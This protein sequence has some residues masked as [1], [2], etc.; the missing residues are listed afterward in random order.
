M[1]S[2]QLVVRELKR[3]IGSLYFEGSGLSKDKEKLAARVK[4]G[5]ETFEPRLAVR[6]PYVF[7]FLGLRSRE[8]MGESD[9]EDALLDRLQEFLLERRFGPQTFSQPVGDQPDSLPVMSPQRCAGSRVAL[10]PV[11]PVVTSVTNCRNGH[12]AMSIRQFTRLRSPS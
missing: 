12:S 5:P 3:Q 11:A 9:L 7:E 10:R 4:V 1:H 6:D 2:G 8:V